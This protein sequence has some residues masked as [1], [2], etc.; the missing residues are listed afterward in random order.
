M[1]GLNLGHPFASIYQNGK[2]DIDD[3]MVQRVLQSVR[4]SDRWGE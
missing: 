4:S 1:F 3:G 2:V